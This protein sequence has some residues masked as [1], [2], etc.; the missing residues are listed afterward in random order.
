[1]EPSNAPPLPQK[2]SCTRKDHL[3]SFLPLSD[4][5]CPSSMFEHVMMMMTTTTRDDDDDDDDD[6]DNDGPGVVVWLVGCI[7]VVGA[8]LTSDRGKL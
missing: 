6:D 5:V 1:M 3:P 4:D 7:C 8:V 2:Q